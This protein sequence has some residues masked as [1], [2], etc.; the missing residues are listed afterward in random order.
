MW[1]DA[2]IHLRTA[3]KVDSESEQTQVFPLFF[4]ANLIASSIAKSCAVYADPLLGCF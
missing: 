4:A 1:N 2:L 3:S